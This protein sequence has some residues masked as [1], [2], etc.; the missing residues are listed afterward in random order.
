MRYRESVPHAGLRPFVEAIW[1]MSSAAVVPN[2]RA[3]TILPDGA[4]EIVVSFGGP[5]GIPPLRRPHT[6]VLLGPSDRVRRVT[7]SGVVDLVGFRLRPG[8]A[9]AI[10]QS[11][12]ARVVNRLV[13]LVSAAPALDAALESSLDQRSSSTARSDAVQRA[14]EAFVRQLPR[15]NGF[16]QRSVEAIHARQGRIRIEELASEL[17]VSRRQLERAFLANIGLSPKRWCRVVRFQHAVQS[18]SEQRDCDWADLAYRLGYADQAHFCR[19]FRTFTEVA[20]TG[21][22]W[23]R[24]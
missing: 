24:G 3:G 16:F 10:V 7:Y 9:R 14:I 8:I 1:T 4:V 21:A 12:L 19:E 23:P 13:P 2:R 20:P 15:P 22:W 17:S 18:M 5:I 11:P 6:R